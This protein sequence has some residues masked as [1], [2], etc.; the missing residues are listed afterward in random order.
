MK[1]ATHSRPQVRIGFKSGAVR[2]EFYD[3]QSFDGR[4]LE[5]L[6]NGMGCWTYIE[7]VD[8][9][10]G[11]YK[12][13]TPKYPESSFQPILKS[14]CRS[15]GE[16]RTFTVRAMYKDDMQNSPDEL[17]VEKNGEVISGDHVCYHPINVRTAHMLPLRP[18][19]SELAVIRATRDAPGPPP[20]PQRAAR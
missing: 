5:N 2:R 4:F 15:L 17:V 10:Y 1:S 8:Q 16:I 11:P 19:S 18:D 3:G 6:K 9:C 20:P 13:G 14:P 7:E 12:K